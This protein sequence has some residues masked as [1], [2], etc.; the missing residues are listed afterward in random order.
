MAK[1]LS[2]KF[3]PKDHWIYKCGVVIGGK[4]YSHF[5]KKTKEKTLDNEANKPD[6]KQ[7]DEEKT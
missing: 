6:E 2:I 7:S 4:T 1:K 5:P 3:L